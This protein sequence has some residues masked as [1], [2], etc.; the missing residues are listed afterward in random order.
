MLARQP[1]GDIT[2]NDPLSAVKYPDK[3]SGNPSDSE[4]ESFTV[5]ALGDPKTATDRIGN[6]HTYTY[7]VLGRQTADTVTTLIT[8][9]DGA[10]RRLG[11][12]FDTGGR[13]YLYTS[14]S[15]T[16][17]TNIVNQVQD[18]YNGLGQL[19]TEYQAVSGAV[20]TGTT[21]KVQYAYSE[22][23]GGANHSRLISMTY[24]NGRVLNYNYGTSG[25]LDDKISRLT[26]ITDGATTLESYTY[27]GLDTVVKRAHPQPNVD[28]SYIN[29]PSGSTDGGD[30]YTG[31]DRFG[32]VIDQ[33][34]INN[35]TSTV[36]DRFQ[37]GFDRND[38]RQYRKNAINA[39]FSELYH[40]NGA[41]N[42]YDPLNQI[43]NFQRG[44][45]NGTNDSITGTP[46]ATN[47]WT[48]DAMGNFGTVG[49]QTR[50]H[51]QQNQITSIS[52][53]TTPTYDANGNMT[54]D[55]NGK[56][57]VFDA[58]NRLVAYKNG[59][60]TL[61]SYSYDALSRRITENPGTARIFTTRLHG[62]FLRSKTIWEPRK[63]STFGARFM[64]TP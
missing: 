38:N 33:Y 64:S 53:L 17:G 42:G 57:L 3:I 36:T 54:G 26:S 16:T 12:A 22:M 21:P 11:T 56:T 23:T 9:T 2:S 49:P 63:P 55:Q 35:T 8:G 15:D 40:A 43:T 52:G 51:N 5:N 58:W 24:P 60:T 46:S 18:A 50:T 27:L 4:K 31:L 45:L 32:R 14:Y 48:M 28:L 10:V 19:I 39:V 1:S 34:W 20:V 61:V 41:S 62:K 30:Q 59:G 29:Q 47:A 37:Y 6:V 44:T 7:D 13:P 25:S